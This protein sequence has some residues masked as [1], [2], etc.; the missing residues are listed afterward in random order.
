MI[1][2]SRKR[3]PGLHHYPLPELE[4]GVIWYASAQ[5]RCEIRFT[6]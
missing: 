5:N 4:S 3:P 1:K 2:R 6:L